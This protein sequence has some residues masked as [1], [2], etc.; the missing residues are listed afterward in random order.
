MNTQITSEDITRLVQ[1][2]V[3]EVHPLKIF[4][5]G[6]SVRGDSTADSDIDLLVV[7]RDGVHRRKIAQQIYRNISNA[8]IP[9]DILVATVTDIEEHR[10]NVGLIYHQILQKGKEVYAA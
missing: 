7:M 6:S 2:I 10:D 5:F 1:K 9:F 3:T 8:G 4:L